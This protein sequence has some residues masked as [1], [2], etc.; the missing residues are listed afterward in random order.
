[1]EYEC[2]KCGSMKKPKVVNYFPPIIVQCLECA[3]KNIE[4]SFIKKDIKN[5]NENDKQ[6][7]I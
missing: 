4:A 6:L 1:M 7:I 3:H 5:L 2:P